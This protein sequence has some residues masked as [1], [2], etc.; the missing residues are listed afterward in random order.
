MK[1]GGKVPK[2]EL[3]RPTNDF[4]FKALFGREEKECKMILMDLLNAIL[5][6]KSPN[7]IT[8]ITYLNPF[9]LKEFKEDKLSI[10][11]IK[12]K[13]AYGERINIEMQVSDVDDYRKRSLYYWS[14]LYGETII[15]SEV[16]ET[17]Q[18]S[19]MINIMNFNLIN[20]TDK[21]HTVFKIIEEEEKFLLI[22]D[23]EIHYIELK[24]FNDM[25]NIDEMNEIE[26][27]ITF[28][29]HAGREGKEHVIDKLTERSENIKM[30]EKM[31]EKIS[32]DELMRQKYLAVEKAR[33][34]EKSRIYYAEK[35][36]KE[37]GKIEG[38]IEIA[39]NL[40]SMDLPLEDVAK[41]TKLSI[42]EVKKLK[43]D[44]V[45]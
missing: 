17:L 32:A 23:L 24:K 34:D 38:A 29:K 27:W 35:R 37:A 42:E 19:I 44:N 11:D 33:R 43:K 20:E 39:K 9:N 25:K 36:G 14:K 26:R 15:E 2:N 18:K 21:Y 7:I 31:L 40:I 8:E 41:A 12:V 45:Q 28:I 4:V 10:L 5:K 16:Y 13:T 1:E 6:L 22:D 3:L 30:A